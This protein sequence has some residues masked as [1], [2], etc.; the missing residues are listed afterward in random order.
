M[1]TKLAFNTENIPPET[2]SYVC[3]TEIRK[4]GGKVSDDPSWYFKGELKQSYQ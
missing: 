2:T 3:D 4:G 1:F